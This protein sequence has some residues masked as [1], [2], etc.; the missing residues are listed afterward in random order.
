MGEGDVDVGLCEGVR[1]VRVFHGDWRGRV[2]IWLFGGCYS[3]CL[4]GVNDFLKT[5]GNKGFNGAV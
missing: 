5:S 3:V 4:N 2:Y 1:G